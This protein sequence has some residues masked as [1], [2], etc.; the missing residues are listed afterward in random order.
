MVNKTRKLLKTQKLPTIP[1]AIPLVALILLAAFILSGCVQ[2]TVIY[3]DDVSIYG[4]IYEFQEEEEYGSMTPYEKELSALADLKTGKPKDNMV[5]IEVTAPDIYSIVMEYAEGGAEFNNAQDLF[6]AIM[7]KAQDNNCKKVTRT[8]EIS[9][10]NRNGKWYAASS[11]EYRDAI[12]GGLYTATNGIARRLAEE[13]A[14]A[15]KEGQD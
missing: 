13:A 15:V 2:E 8:I 3:F 9:V 6:N 4:D 1:A 12:T 14:R 7:E 5:S 11:P 10:V